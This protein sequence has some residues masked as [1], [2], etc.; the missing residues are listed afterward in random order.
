MHLVMYGMAKTKLPDNPNTS[1]N[2]IRLPD[3][4]ESIQA[5]VIHWN[6]ALVYLTLKCNAIDL[7]GF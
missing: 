1:E 7:F 4:N 2:K 5:I 3:N 6:L